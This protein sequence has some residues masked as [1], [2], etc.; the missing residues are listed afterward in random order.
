VR[1]REALRVPLN[2]LI[3]RALEASPGYQF[4]FVTLEACFYTVR[5]L[6]LSVLLVWSTRIVCITLSLVENS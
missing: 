1:D 5:R 4:V 6:P 2:S 3:S